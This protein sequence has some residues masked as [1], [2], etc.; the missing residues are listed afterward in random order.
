MKIQHINFYYV[1]M[2]IFSL[3]ISSC[4]EEEVNYTTK[5][6]IDFSKIENI[7]LVQH[8]EK[9]VC[10]EF[11]EKSMLGNLD[12]IVLKDEVFFVRSLE[13]LFLFDKHGKLLSKIGSK[14]VSQGEYTHFNSFFIKDDKVFIYD[15]QSKKVIEYDFTGKYISAVELNQ[16]YD[17]ITPNFIYLLPD[18]KFIS[19][20][21]FGGDNRKIPSYSILGTDYKIEHNI[22]GRYLKNGITSLNN[23]N[24]NNGQ[25]MLFWEVLNDTIFSIEK[26]QTH[27]K[28][29]VDFQEKSIPLHMQKKPLYE[30]I[31]FSNQPEN[32]DR[33]ASLIQ[34]VYE[35]EDFLRF[36]FLFQKKLHYVKYDKG[37]NRTK[38]YSLTYGNYAIGQN[39]LFQK[40]NL[41]VTVTDL[42]SIESNSC[43]VVIDES[44]L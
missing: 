21:T 37:N 26:D 36:T 35:S 34:N 40:N 18:G 31:Q 43:L 12:E 42:E 33:Y 13:S 32:I 41:Y 19:R 6:L 29:A 2:V 44:I 27:P 16:V 25:Q 22:L 8:A 17:S 14:G 15:A 28:Y 5:I 9:K 39:I 1:G 24:I 7:D 11:S 30:L 4:K 20:N 3:F 23:F 38:V 10:F